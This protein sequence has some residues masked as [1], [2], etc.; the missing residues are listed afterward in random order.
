MRET[1]FHHRQ[2][3]T[4]LTALLLASLVPTLLFGLANAIRSRN[5]LKQQAER[6]LAYQVSQV[7]GYASQHEARIKAL[8]EDEQFHSA[9]NTLLSTPETSNEN[10][11]ARA[12]FFG[13]FQK[14]QT[15]QSGSE[16][17]QILLLRPD[18]TSALATG[19]EWIEASIRGLQVN[20]QPLLQSLNGVDK[21]LFAIQPAGDSPTRLFFL[22]SHTLSDQKGIPAGTLVAVAVT[23]PGDLTYHAISEAGVLLEGAKGYYFTP[24]SAWIKAGSDQFTSMAGLPGLTETQLLEP[25]RQQT[26]YIATGSSGRMAVYSRWLAEYNLG[27]ILTMPDPAFAVLNMLVDPFNLAAFLVVLAL[28]GALAYYV[29]RRYAQESPTPDHASTTRTG[30]SSAVV[31][32][33]KPETGLA[34]PVRTASGPGANETELP[35]SVLETLQ[36]RLAELQILANFSQ[37]ISAETDINHLYRVL[38]EQVIQTFGPDLQFAVAIYDPDQ[39]LIQFP[40]FYENGQVVSIPPSRLGEGLT[41]IV[42]QSRSPLLFATQQEVMQRYSP[43]IHGEPAQSWLGIPLIFAGSVVGAILIQDLQT[44]NRFD[45][46]DLNLFMTLAPQI[47]TFIR[48]AQLYGELINAEELAQRRAEQVLT[49]AEIARDATGTLDVKTLLEKAV[50]LVR[51]RFGFY[52]ASIFLIDPAGEYAVLRE[53]TGIAGHQLMQ[54]GH[55]LAVGSRSI[56]GQVTGAGKSLIVNDVTRDP[57]HLPNQYLPDT[58]SELAIPLKVGERILGALDVQSTKFD[59]FHSEDI[60][61]LEILADQLAV[62]VVNGELFAKAQE[63]LGKHRLLRQITI[64]ASASSTLEDA[65]TNVVSGLRTALVSERISILLLN[66]DGSLQTHASA[67]Y[68]GTRYLE[69][70][71]APGQGIS[72]LAAAEKRPIRVDETLN[73]PR[74]INL[75][76]DVRSELAVP[77]L[78]GDQLIGVLNLESTRLYAF[79]ENDQEIIGALGS[80]L[81]GVIANMR[82]I[83]QVRQQVVRERQLYDVTSKIRQ[84]VDLQ[85]ILETSTKEITRALGARSARI[86]INV[87]SAPPEEHASGDAPEPEGYNGQGT[88]SNNGRAASKDKK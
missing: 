31:L 50:E 35:T 75:D 42:I 51:E 74:Y 17:Q 63:L 16:F 13:A 71:I 41:S 61:V 83:N 60:S 39:N 34:E 70:R 14:N 72:G 55:R 37:S 43:I 66:Q 52:H 82:L 32:E 84:S 36:S 29:M 53:S 26:Q 7:T 4:V 24:G 11:Q 58:R 81:G 10:K 27:V 21:A 69:T 54:T 2:V 88:A 78:F 79:D 56:V 62:A 15:A 23:S 30:S 18:G 65:L 40:Y 59:A 86:R 76:A 87:H 80:N 67:G 6:V 47:A 5:L 25:A 85:T 45:K 22:A 73:D 33:S 44:E 77:I 57:T 49:A 8:S 68:E 38:H 28:A 64:A 46:N 1:R 19:E 48:N 20:D 9:A 3:R 12:I